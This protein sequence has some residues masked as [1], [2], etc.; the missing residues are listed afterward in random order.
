MKP[1]SALKGHNNKA[2][3]NALGRA[4]IIGLI[5]QALKARHRTTVAITALSAVLLLTQCNRPPTNDSERIKLAASAL[6]ARGLYR[7][8]LDELD[9]YR[10]AASLT[11]EAEADLLFK[12]GQMADQKLGDC[13]RA[14]KYYTVA[15]SLRPDA[16]WSKDSGQASVKCLDKLGKTKDSAAL[17]RQLT[18]DK[19]APASPAGGEAKKDPG[20]VVAVVDG[21][22]VT[23]TEV[24]AALPQSG[25]TA[26]DLAARQK[27]VAGY[28]TTLMI[29]KDARRKG[30]DADPAFS[31]QMD[32]GREQ[33]LAAAYVKREL[34]GQKDEAAMRAAMDSLAKLY[35]VRV[36]LEAVPAP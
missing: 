19:S 33:A 32:Y 15:D 21:H 16:P 18:G 9:R 17:L 29:A 31:A 6:E 23:W 22:S 30:Y 36:F 34:T 2:Q 14:L 13:D 24:E 7:A 8:A 11:R 1:F 25:A 35:E 20:P 5:F 27:M 26:P 10:V 12:M 3:G 4:N 28:V